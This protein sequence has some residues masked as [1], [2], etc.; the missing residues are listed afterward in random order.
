MAEVS[1]LTLHEKMQPKLLNLATILQI[2]QRAEEE[3]GLRLVQMTPDDVVGL[4][5][6][7]EEY[8]QFAETIADEIV[9]TLFG[10]FDA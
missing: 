2:I 1:K 8:E 6:L 10:T 3:S 5:P 9:L 4:P 7:P